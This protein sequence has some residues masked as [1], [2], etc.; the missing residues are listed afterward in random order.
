MPESENYTDPADLVP[1][2]DEGEYYE[3][4]V[5]CPPEGTEYCM[6]CWG[7]GLVKHEC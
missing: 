1:G 3:E 5:D 7:S 2:L 6:V 4:C